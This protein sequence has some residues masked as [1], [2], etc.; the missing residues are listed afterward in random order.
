MLVRY[1]SCVEGMACSGEIMLDR[2]SVY[3]GGEVLLTPFV[4]L[5]LTFI[6]FFVPNQ[7]I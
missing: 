2:E 6:S 5:T 3:S 4:W 7:L 1:R